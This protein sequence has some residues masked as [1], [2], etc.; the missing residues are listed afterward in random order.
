M[1]V[2]T[3]G[4]VVESVVLVCRYER[5]LARSEP[6]LAIWRQVLATPLKNE[7]NLIAVWVAVM[8]VNTAW[9]ECACAKNDV[10]RADGFSS[11]E[12]VDPESDKAGVLVKVSIALEIAQTHPLDHGVRARGDN[13][14]E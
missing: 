8:F 14:P 2:T 13:G 11:D 5:D 10:L 4:R 7:E 6:G 1:R 12:P 3:L 9:F